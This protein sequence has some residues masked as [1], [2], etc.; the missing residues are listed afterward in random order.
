MT[1]LRTVEFAPPTW[2]GEPDEDAFTRS[3]RG[4]G[5]LYSQGLAPA[6]V[7]ARCPRLQLHCYPHEPG[8]T[9]VEVTVFTEPTDEYEM[10]GI[11]LPDGVAALP[12]R[13]RAALVLDVMHG[14]ALRMAQA[15][16][17]DPA[18]FEAARAHVV[19]HDLRFRWIGPAKK[20][21]GRTHVARPVFT[22]GDDGLARVVVEIRRAADDTLVACSPELATTDT[23]RRVAAT[24][25]WYDRE[26]AQID[27]GEGPP[28]YTEV[29]ELPPVTVRGEGANAPEA[30]PQITVIGG[31]TDDAVPETYHTA[32]HVLLNQVS[33]WTPWWSAADD[34]VLE[35]SYDLIAER[36]ARVTA[37]RGGNKLR[38]RI[39]RPLAT[40]AST[41]DPI[42]LAHADIENLLAVVRRRAALGPHPALP[43]LPALRTATA[44]ET[45]GRAALINRM[46]ALLDRL[47]D[48]LP[49]GF[50][51]M[52]HNDLDQSR[53]GDAMAALRTQPDLRLT[54]AEQTE[55]EALVDTQR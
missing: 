7:A 16:G 48:R 21:P 24:L 39:E 22:I 34:D 18:A 6:R 46:R 35:I 9:A 28:Q 12:P 37:R 43:G 38:V 19:A 1:V 33:T 32:L 42:A 44:N 29:P 5:E 26:I 50:V 14:A 31:Y 51:G 30:P 4:I 13:A 17:W 15:R 54:E 20:S 40:L 10:A 8:R 53:T 36:P 11:L 23:H 27:P 52:L 45:D 25:R 2:D 41:P 3:A 47:S 49:T 55:L